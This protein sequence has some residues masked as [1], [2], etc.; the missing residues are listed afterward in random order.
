[1]S[2]KRAK[3]RRP[4]IS[5]LT[6][7]GTKDWFTGAM[8]GVILG[9]VPEAQIVDISHDVPPQDVAGAA[10]ILNA[11]HR[12][13]PEGTVFCCVVDPEVGTARR[14]IAATDGVYYYVAP[15]NGLL[16]GIES[17]AETFLAYSIENKDLFHKGQGATFE[18]R[19][20]FAPAAAALAIRK[21]L[22]EFGPLC[23][24][25]RRLE[26]HE[27]VLND[28]GVLHGRV[29]YTDRFGNLV[30]NITLEDIPEGI[31]ALTIQVQNTR[32]P[33]ISRCYDCVR[34]GIFVAYWGSAGYLEIAMNRG[35]AAETL[36]AKPGTE[37]T[38]HSIT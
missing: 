37:V 23:E 32:I 6:D 31:G 26:F 38:I 36:S 33:E 11:C 14:R 25:F 4:V 13:F 30:T 18:G 12:D 29:A 7:F 16:S 5:L 2:S 34:N 9:L 3:N 35:N 1:M 22:D 15:D 10:F 17:R 8:K 20:V 21:P 28:S 24:D 27:P 19:D